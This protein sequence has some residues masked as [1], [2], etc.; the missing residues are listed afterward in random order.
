MVQLGSSPANFQL[1]KK[2]DPRWR[3]ITSTFS[4]DYLLKCPGPLKF[5]WRLFYPPVLPPPNLIHMIKSDLFFSKGFAASNKSPRYRDKPQRT[6]SQAKRERAHCS[7]WVSSCSPHNTP[8]PA[9]QR[10]PPPSQQQ[11]LTD[12]ASVRVRVCKNIGLLEAPTVGCGIQEELGRKGKRRAGRLAVDAC[13]REER[14]RRRDGGLWKAEKG[15]KGVV[16][17][18]GRERRPHERRGRWGR[19]P[20][21]L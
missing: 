7:G 2:T 21:L 3:S 6:K 8:C 14:G 17:V 13:G 18:G 19:G 5:I 10:P 4:C 20:S 12:P 9:G 11:A 1:P 15:K 16:E